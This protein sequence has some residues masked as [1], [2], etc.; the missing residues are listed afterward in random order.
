MIPTFVIGLREGLEASLIVGIVA[1]FLAQH[2]PSA[3]RWMWLGV[4]S[5]VAI[6]TAVGVGLHVISE[7]LPQK[8]QEG[9]ETIVALLAVAAITYMIVWMRRNA[10]GLK[11]ALETQASE[12]L[13][14]GSVIGLVGMAFFAVIREGFETTVFLLAAFNATT[15]PAAA[16]AGAALGLLV[17]IGLGFGIYRGG[18]RINLSRFFTVTGFALVVVA[19]GLVASAAHTA[20]E[21]G[22][23]DVAQRQALDL[24]WLVTPGSVRSALITGMLGIQPQPTVAEVTGYLVYLVPLLAFVLWPRSRSLGRVP[25][26]LTAVVLAVPA[27][28]FVALAV[29]SY[30]SGTGSAQAGATTSSRVVRVALTASGCPA[31]LELPSGRTIFVVSNHGAN[32][33]SEIE[34]WQGEAMRG[35]V[36]N[37]TPG[38]SGTFS[39]TLRPGV[40]VTNCPGGT[41][42]AHGRLRVS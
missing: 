38:L 25:R 9:L 22:W 2:R 4:V 29:A 6:C 8:Q 33:V 23:L 11:L 39:L 20:N 17:A 16:G 36:E 14:Q 18:V 5:A 13:A 34:I 10:R 19:A 27:A 7:D 30:G 15:S 42:F 28:L 31:S 3:L 21:A 32:D 37:I 1:A 41:R 40:Y 26:W 24:S 12:A 35:E